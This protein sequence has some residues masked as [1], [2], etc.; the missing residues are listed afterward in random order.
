MKS[1]KKL[2]KIL[3]LLCITTV[4]L[5]LSTPA[6]ALQAG[7]T[8]YLIAGENTI[9]YVSILFYDRNNSM[10]D[11]ITLSNSAIYSATIPDG[12]TEVRFEGVYSNTDSFAVTAD[13]P[14]GDCNTYDLADETWMNQEETSDKAPDETDTQDANKTHVSASRDSAT[15]NVKGKIGAASESPEEIVSVD[16]AWGEMEFTYTPATQGTWN[17][18]THS[19]D[20]GSEA[21]W[22][23]IGNE[24][25]VTNHSNVGVTASFAFDTAEGLEIK[26]GFYADNE[27]VTSVSLDSAENPTEEKTLSKTVCFQVESGTITKDTD[28]LGTITVTIE[29]TSP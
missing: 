10:V 29:K 28:S 13:I 8:I 2:K 25:S 15:I 26:G 6:H 17:P 11:M 18:T 21:G 19:Y 4:S 27:E 5:M 9:S 22:S 20:G 24:I 1:M 7:D 23:A 3:S 16:V 14:A 12:A